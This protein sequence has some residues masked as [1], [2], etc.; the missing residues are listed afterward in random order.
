VGAGRYGIQSSGAR[1]IIDSAY[2]KSGNDVGAPSRTTQILASGIAPANS[3]T[4]VIIY[5]TAILN[6]TEAGD[7]VDTTTFNMAFN[8]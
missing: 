8:F 6:I 2:D 7:Y 4:I 1:A 5:K 3:H